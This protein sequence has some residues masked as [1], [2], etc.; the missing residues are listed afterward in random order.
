MHA[1][2]DHT[3]YLDEYMGHRSAQ[4]FSMGQFVKH[5]SGS[6]DGVIIAGDFNTR[7]HDVGYNVL[8]SVGVVNDAWLDA[9]G[10]F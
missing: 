5:T 7:P 8:R 6:C 4:A 2:H 9:V 3:R 10:I 1:R